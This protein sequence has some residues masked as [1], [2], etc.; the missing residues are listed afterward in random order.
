V[1]S[2]EKPRPR[3]LALTSSADPMASVFFLRSVLGSLFSESC[4]FSSCSLPSV[5][6]PPV[7]CRL[8]FVLCPCS[9][10]GPRKGAQGIRRTGEP[11]SRSK[12]RLNASRFVPKQTSTATAR[13]SAMTDLLARECFSRPS[14]PVSALSTPSARS[15]CHGSPSQ[16]RELE[17]SGAPNILGARRNRSRAS[18]SAFLRQRWEWSGK[19]VS[20]RSRGQ[21]SA[22]SSLSFFSS[23]LLYA[24]VGILRRRVCSPI[25]QAGQGD[26]TI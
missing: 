1:T 11:H 15:A 10:P 26:R 21:R 4:R 6:C 2:V 12:V 20:P 14:H 3:V 7:R 17:Q 16:H 8:S 25:G 5:H 18:R 19:G 24:Q 9:P 22:P 23:L 13:I